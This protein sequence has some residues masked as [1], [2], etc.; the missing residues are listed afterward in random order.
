MALKKTLMAATVAAAMLGIGSQ[1]QACF[2]VI[3]G[4]DASATGEILVGHNEDND[5]RI[6]MSQYW[7]PA[8]KH[9]KGEMIRFEDSTARIPQVAE[10][11]GFWWTQTLSP[12]GYSFSDGFFNE[13]GVLITSNNCGDTVEKDEKTRQG[14]VGYGIR[15]ITAERAHTAREAVDI[16][17]DLVKKYGYTHEGRTYTF[18]DRNEAWQVALLRG[19]RYLARKVKDNEVAFLANSFS[20][21]QVDFNDKE[22]VIASPDLI[23]HAMKIGTYKPVKDGD[24]SDFVFRDAYQPDRRRAADWNAER[25]KTF[26][27]IMTGETIEDH[28]AIPQSIIPKNK[29]TVQ[30]LQKVLRGQSK[31]VDRKAGGWHLYD[32]RDIGNLDTHDSSIFKL[33]QNP[34]LT[35]SWRTNARPYETVYVPAFP[36]AKPPA[37][38]SFMDPAT[39]TKAQFHATP[40]QM[41]FSIDRNVYTFVLAQQ[42]LD[43][44]P[45]L[46]EDVLD[47]IEDYEEKVAKRLPAIEARAKALAAIDEARA[48]EFMHNFNVLSYNEVLGMAS[49]V[50]MKANQQDI[51]I[52]KDTL[53]LS[54][55]KGTVDVVLLSKKGFDATKIDLAATEFG[56]AWSDGNDEVN[57]ERARPTNVVFKDVDGDGLNDAVLTF[58]VKGAVATTFADVYTELF[59]YTRVDG[60]PVAAFDTVL[61][62]K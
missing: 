50:L 16:A 22:N 53:S 56:S 15:R 60:K 20:L 10:T 33:T 55:D 36:M 8:A 38:Q 39:G 44:M 18:A 31:N 59:L 45:D 32:M 37:A 26:M 54:D 52:M 23:E 3:V 49:K 58:P 1:A 24:F 17:I 40:E 7:V 29:V 47:D 13:A 30:D 46:R 34:L 28:N 27:E 42:F 4:K 11:L 12:D 62:K 41:S 14:G 21:T 2:T 48:L 9:K 43:W 51:V 35:V 5:R 61:I 57:K 6:L 19:S 25:V